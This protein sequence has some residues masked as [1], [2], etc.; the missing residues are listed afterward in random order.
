VAARLQ[1]TSLTYTKASQKLLDLPYGYGSAAS[2]NGQILSIT[3]SSDQTL[4]PGAAG[5]SVTYTY[6]ALHRLKTAETVGSTDYAKWG[7]TWTYD[8][9][10]NRTNQAILS[11]CV[12]PMTCPTNP[13]TVDAATNR[14]TGAP[15]AYDANGNMTNDGSNTLAYDAANRLISAA[16]A[17]YTYDGG[18]LRVKKVSGTTTT[19]YVFSG[20]KVIAEYENGAAVGSPTREYIYTGSQLLAKIEVG[21]TTYSHPDHLSAR[22]MTNSTGTITAQSAHYPFGENWYE[23]AANKLKFTSYERDSGASESGNDSAIFRSYISRLGRLNSP[24]PI[25]GR[26]D[27]P[28]SLSRYSY[29]RYDPIGYYDPLGLKTI[30]VWKC[31]IVG[32]DRE[33]SGEEACLFEYEINIP[34]VL[35]GDQTKREGSLTPELRKLLEQ[36][37]RNAACAALFD[38]KAEAEFILSHMNIQEVPTI[39]R[40]PILLTDMTRLEVLETSIG[41][42]AAPA[43]VTFEPLWLSDYPRTE[44]WV[45]YGAIEVRVNSNFMSQS[46]DAQATLLLH[47]VMHVAWAGT[48]SMS[49]TLHNTLEANLKDIANKCKTGKPST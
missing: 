40:G 26:V 22:V 43:G 2:N 31:W 19:V 28:Q 45:G 46:L 10:G 17:T 6:D 7:L 15:Y 13:V 32:P 36:A 5:R 48:P 35:L 23:T 11:G 39:S 3:D 38:G 1:L 37:L 49:N 27:D 34:D 20:T 29:V 44:P 14:I 30:R 12:A 24:D 21:A 16:A 9:F 33:N 41:R 25:A 4:T 18:P 42:G 8:R 47:E